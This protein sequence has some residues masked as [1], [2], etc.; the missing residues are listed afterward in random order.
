MPAGFL[1]LYEWSSRPA[2]ANV[3]ASKAKLTR[4]TPRGG[5]GQRQRRRTEGGGGGRTRRRREDAEEDGVVLRKAEPSTR[6]KKKVSY[7]FF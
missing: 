3:R 4:E 6:L 5:R 7:C 2:T 1:Y